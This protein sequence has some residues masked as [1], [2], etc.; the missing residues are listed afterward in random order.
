MC[1]GI[2]IP[3]VGWIDCLQ[4]CGFSLAF[5]V[6]YVEGMFRLQVAGEGNAGSLAQLHSLVHLQYLVR[7]N[8]GPPPRRTHCVVLVSF[9]SFAGPS[10]FPREYSATFL[11]EPR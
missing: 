1:C 8:Y 5:Q 9:P 7:S 10:E 11:T 2:R 4:S 6:L 3:C